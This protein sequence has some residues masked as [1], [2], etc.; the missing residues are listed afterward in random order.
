MDRRTVTHNDNVVVVSLWKE[1]SLQQAEDGTEKPISLMCDDD[2]EHRDEAFGGSYGASDRRHWRQFERA[3]HPTGVFVEFLRISCTNTPFTTTKNN[4]TMTMT[5]TQDPGIAG[6]TNYRKWDKVASDLVEDVKAQEQQEAEEA[7]KKMGLDGKY[8]LSQSEAEERLKAKQAKHTK[9]AL[10]KYKQR[11]DQ[12]I[13]SFS[14]LLGPVESDKNKTDA[15]KDASVVRITRDRVDAGNR[16]LT[17]RDTS[18]AST[19]DMIVLTQDLSLLESKMKAN[20]TTTPNHYAEDAENSTQRRRSKNTQCV[21]THQTIP[22][23]YSQL[24]SGDS[25]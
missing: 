9:K 6:R 1:G 15:N 2:K 14:G 11:E 3:D 17:I 25:L 24:Y 18:G 4:N 8:A 20:A 5:T 16:V 19:K 22:F 21:R 10:D 7:A 23:Q 12:V 13:Q